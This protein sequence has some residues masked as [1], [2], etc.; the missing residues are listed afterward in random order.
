MEEDLLE[1][2]AASCHAWTD[3][4]LRRSAGLGLV[5]TK[6]SR[7]SG[8]TLG[9]GSKSLGGKQ[10]AFD[11]E[12]AAI[13][14]AIKWF[15]KRSNLPSLI[16]RSDSTSAI[17]RASHTG[18]GPGQGHALN[19][20]RIMVSALR[21]RGRLVAIAWVKGHAGTPG[22]ERADVLAGN[23]AEKAGTGILV[24]SLAFLKL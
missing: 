18:A 19:I 12:V 17:A 24:A 3:G 7:G 15:L 13:E 1:P 4:S 6:D 8:N 9:L 5:V 2:E 11:A 20:H 16:I 21:R 10:V 14:E 22:N 23:A